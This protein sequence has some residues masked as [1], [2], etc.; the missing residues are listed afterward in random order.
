MTREADEAAEEDRLTR[1][2]LA[3]LDAQM[4]AQHAAKAQ[5]MER[6]LASMFRDLDVSG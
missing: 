3:D 2:M 6:L 1:I 5:R 4:D